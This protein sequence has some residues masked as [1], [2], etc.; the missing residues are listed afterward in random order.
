MKL[1]LLFFGL[2]KCNYKHRNFKQ[3]IIIDYEK[4]YEIIKIYF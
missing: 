1:G 4:S 3:K 2:S